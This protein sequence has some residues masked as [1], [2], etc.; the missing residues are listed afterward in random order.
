VNIRGKWL[1][2]QTPPIPQA[3]GL[4][5]TGMSHHRTEWIIRMFL[6][7]RC[8]NKGWLKVHSETKFRYR[9]QQ[10]EGVCMFE[11]EK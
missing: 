10:K 2:L 7:I 11:I 5:P 1:R 6:R 4:S 9:K 3:Q 8:G